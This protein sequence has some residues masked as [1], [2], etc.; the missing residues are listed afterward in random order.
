MSLQKLWA[1]CS[2]TTSEKHKKSDKQQQQQQQQQR[3]FATSSATTALP[4]PVEGTNN[5]PGRSRRQLLFSRVYDSMSQV[6]GLRDI[7]DYLQVRVTEEAGVTLDSSVPTTATGSLSWS[8]NLQPLSVG[9]L[10]P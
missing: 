7:Q 10:I 2:T 8:T 6:L 1:T 9:A 4:V 3:G 5:N